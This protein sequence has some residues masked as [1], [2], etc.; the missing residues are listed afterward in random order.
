MNNYWVVGAV[1]M[2]VAA[3]VFFARYV[4]STS[5]EWWKSHIEN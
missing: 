3:I 1:I 4:H 2:A 5:I